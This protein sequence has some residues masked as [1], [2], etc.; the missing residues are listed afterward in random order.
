M[1]RRRNHNE[2]STFVFRR[3]ADAELD[4][5][6]S[7]FNF[8][9]YNKTGTIERHLAGKILL[10]IGVEPS[11][12]SLPAKISF[13]DLAM[14]I[15]GKLPDPEL[16]LDCSLH[17]FVRM[18]GN[19]EADGMTRNLRPDGIIDFFTELDRPAP[20]QG[21]A[22]MLLAGMLDYD[23]VDADVKVTDKLFS[24]ELV[25]FSKKS[26]ALREFR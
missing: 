11:V 8:Y 1:S 16:P 12:I 7:Q 26:N 15:D 13:Q 17:T 3:L 9:D 4:Y 21:E 5:I 2:K 19:V 23:N 22:S 20:T 18:V 24:R 6:R 25:G 10:N 14:F